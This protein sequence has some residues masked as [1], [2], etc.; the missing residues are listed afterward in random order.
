[1]KDKFKNSTFYKNLEKMFSV[2]SYESFLLHDF[3]LLSNIGLTILMI[4]E[5]TLI[6]GY[7]KK[8]SE[9]HFIH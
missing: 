4:V 1:M 5:L 8:P 9:L 2:G 7:G 3:L 6:F